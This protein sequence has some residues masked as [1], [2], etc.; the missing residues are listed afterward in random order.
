LK[1]AQ[2]CHHHQQP[3]LV[4]NYRDSTPGINIAPGSMHSDVYEQATAEADASSSR[5]PIAA[6]LGAA[7]AKRAATA[8]QL[9]KTE[10]SSSDDEFPDDLRS[11]PKIYLGPARD[12]DGH[13]LHNV[14]II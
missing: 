12:E 6:H 7:A 3:E 9:I 11:E 13:E 1:A 5:D 14:D 2:Q 4:V 8:A 10:Q